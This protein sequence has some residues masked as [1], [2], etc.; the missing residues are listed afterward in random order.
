MGG[1]INRVMSS[2]LIKRLIEPLIFHL[3]AREEQARVGLCLYVL[4]MTD[5]LK[6]AAFA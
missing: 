2:K 5:T 4:G 6:L 1:Q 3:V